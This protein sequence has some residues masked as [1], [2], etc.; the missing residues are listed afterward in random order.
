M[1]KTSRQGKTSRVPKTRAGG[2]WTEAAFWG[3]I[4]SNLRKM[5]VRW[6][7]RQQAMRAA[8]R[9]YRGPNK[10]QKFEVQ[11]AAC[12]GWFKQA[13][14]QVDHVVG[15]GKLA[16]WDDLPIFVSRLLCE[17]DELQILCEPC[18]K[19]KSHAARKREHDG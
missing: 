1:A 14:C 3:Y 16:C 2:L 4:R 13:D 11:C 7:P 5:S 10:R 6:P 9:E 17:P 19:K 15:C 18:H 12:G 8:R